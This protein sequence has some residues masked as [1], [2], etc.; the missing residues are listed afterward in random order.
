[1]K[2]PE[3]VLPSEIDGRPLPE[4]LH[5]IM[6]VLQKYGSAALARD[7]A[8]F[9]PLACRLGGHTYAQIVSSFGGW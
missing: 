6:R 8:Q 3:E 4:V 1:M 7:I 2:C 9:G 5:K